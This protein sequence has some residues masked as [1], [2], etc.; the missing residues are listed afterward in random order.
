MATVLCSSQVMSHVSMFVYPQYD[1]RDRPRKPR[2]LEISL[3]SLPE[4]YTV[5]RGL[6][7]FRS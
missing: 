2:N 3:K 7:N 1:P 6:H 4:V 5:F